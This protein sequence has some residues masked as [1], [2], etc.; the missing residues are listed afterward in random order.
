MNNIN[1][2]IHLK[3][4]IFINGERGYQVIKFLEKKIF[5][6]KIFLSQKFL[7]LKILKKI[8]RLKIPYKI[9]N[10][11][12]KK[13]IT[14]S[15]KKTDL[16]IVCGF[17]YIFQEQYLKLPKFGIINCHAGKL[18]K[19]RGGS[20]LNW[21]I[22]NQEKYIGISVIKMSKK[23]DQGRIINE[24]TILN[25]NYDIIKIHQ[26]VNAIFPNL[27]LKSIKDIINNKNFKKQ[28]PDRAQY[29]KQ[30]SEK[31]SMFYP[32]KLNAS[33]ILALVKALQNP[34]PSPYFID[35][36]KKILI[37]KATTYIKKIKPGFIKYNKNSIIL[38]CKNSG[39]KLLSYE[40]KNYET[41][42]S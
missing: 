3:V 31:D 9:I 22:I 40:I 11:I 39:L 7:D 15:L 35:K 27:V 34:Y 30:R 25:K 17:P 24:E 26:K 1:K 37:K 29:W 2:E 42:S 23:I 8:K 13:I 41:Q 10:N 28:D 21:Q 19:Y 12:E 6:D 20:P 14:T 32:K 16:A 38:G 18:P 5:I 36:N 4:L 33:K